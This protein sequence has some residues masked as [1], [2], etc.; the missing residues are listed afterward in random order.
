MERI[1]VNV[2]TGEIKII[3]LTQEEIDDFLAQQLTKP[4]E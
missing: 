2:A 3:P 1:E 4:T